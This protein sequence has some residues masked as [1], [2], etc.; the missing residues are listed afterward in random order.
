MLHDN[1]LDDNTH[2]MEGPVSSLMQSIGT[3]FSTPF[4]AEE[5]K[6]HN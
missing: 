4:T 3:A 6:N 5:I 2:K 1:T